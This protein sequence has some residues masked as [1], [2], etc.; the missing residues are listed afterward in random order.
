MTYA[1]PSTELT[2]AEC[3]FI[4]TLRDKGH[5]IVVFNVSELGRVEGYD[6]EAYLIEKGNQCLS[7]HNDCED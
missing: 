1:V 2:D 5:A 6:L 4:K 3:E 7:V